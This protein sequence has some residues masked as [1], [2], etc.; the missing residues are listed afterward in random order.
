MGIWILHINIQLGQSP[1]VRV[2]VSRVE[3]M[4]EDITKYEFKSLDGSALPEWSAGAHLD[5]LV[6]PEFLRQ[7]SMSGDPASKGLP[8][9][10]SEGRDR[11]RRIKTIRQFARR[12]ARCLFQSR[13]TILNWMKP[14][15]RPF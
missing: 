12:D 10:R 15:Q 14:L 13:S 2:E 9:R 4:T 8:D 1:V 7:Y 3:K 11:S 5:V 6:A